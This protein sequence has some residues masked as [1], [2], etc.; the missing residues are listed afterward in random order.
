MPLAPIPRSPVGVE[1]SRAGLCG[2]HPEVRSEVR[3]LTCSGWHLSLSSPRSGTEECVVENNPLSYVDPDGLQ[4][5]VV[6]PGGRRPGIRDPDLPPGVGPNHR[7]DPVLQDLIERGANRSEYKNRCDE[8]PPP[9]LNACERAKW[10]LKKWSE[11]KALREA[12]T[13]KWWGGKDTQ[14]SIQL[15]TDININ[16][17]RAERAVKRICKDECP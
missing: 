2:S 8:Q 6:V 4:V 9:G 12:N 17:A 13:N 16:I 3:E 10:E 7:S 15:M 14:H 5:V 1:C 11:C